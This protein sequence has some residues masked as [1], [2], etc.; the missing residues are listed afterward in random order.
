[1]LTNPT[2]LR[3]LNQM[4]TLKAAAEFGQLTRKQ[5]ETFLAEHDLC[6]DEAIAEIGDSVLDAYQLAVWVGY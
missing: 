5:A 3:A 4:T 6:I 2:G 1:M